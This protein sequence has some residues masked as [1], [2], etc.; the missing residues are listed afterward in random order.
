MIDF[1]DQVAIVTGTGRGLG[2]LYALDLARR[3]AAVMVN[4]VGATMHGEG[5]D[6]SVADEV[7]AE[8]HSA[9]GT[10]L[11]SHD[12]VAGPQGGEAIVQAAVEHFGGL[13]VVGGTDRGHF[14]EPGLRGHPS[15][16]LG[17]RRALRAAVRRSESGMVSRC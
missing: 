10:A 9:G 3:G 2:R 4:D 7:V 5:S 12:S 14:G 11:A 16:L 6:S 13:D 1:R 17:L 8:I 15:Q